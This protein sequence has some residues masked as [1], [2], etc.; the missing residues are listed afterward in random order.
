MRKRNLIKKL[1]SLGKRR[2]LLIVITAALLLEMLSAIQ[3]YFTHHL[4]EDELEKRAEMELTMKAIITNG[5]INSSERLLKSH[6]ME[7]KDNLSNPDSL[8]G[9]VEWTLK[10]APHL[11]GCGIA[12]RPGYYKGKGE[13]FEPYALRTDSGI[14]R[15]QVAGE[16]FDYTK[17]GFYRYIQEKKTNS[18]VGPYEDVYLKEKL[19]TYAVPIYDFT[20]DTVAVFG[21]DID[22][23]NLGDTLNK[24]HIYPSSFEFLL[25]E[26]GE[27]I[28][29]PP[30]TSL[31]KK[32]DDLIRVINDSTVKKTW[33]K[34]GRVR[35]IYYHD[36]DEGDDLSV[37]YASIRGAPHWQIAVVCYD[38]EVYA[39]LL[40]LRFRLLL[41]SMLA[42]GILLYMIHRFA[43]EEK[44]LNRKTLEQERI[45]GELRIANSIQQTLLPRD[46]ELLLKGITEVSVEGRL[47]PAKAVGGDLYNSFVRDGKLFFCIGDVSGKGVPSALIMAIVQALFRNIASTENSPDRIMKRLNESSCRNNK[48]NI[49]VTLFVGVLDLPTGR[50]RY[51]NAGHELPMLI[52]QHHTFLDAK[53][54]LP[55]GLFEDFNYEMQTIVMKPGSSMLLY[56]DG[57]TEARNARNEMFGRETLSQLIEDC[58]TTEP[59]VLVE[60]VISKWRHFI[61]TTQQ[62]DDLTLLALSYTPSLEQNIMEEG[63]ILHNDVNEVEAL[64]NFMKQVTEHLNLDKSLAKKLRLAVE[65][66]V[67]NVMEYAYPAGTTGEINIRATSNGNCLKFIIT[68]SGTS[69]NPTKV[70]TADTTLS[71]EERPIGGLGI[72]LVREL[73]DS[74]NYERIDGK[75]VLTLTKNICHTISNVE[76]P[77]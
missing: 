45:V 6:I 4:M 68:D 21:I 66:A 7:V 62:S 12:F 1:L 40:H 61:G 3:Y 20:R 70:Q 47:I 77:K 59:R 32:V 35:T 19:V 49:F 57:L 42:F 25:S 36:E 44:Q 43:K 23:R 30:D 31:K 37:F 5:I 58:G 60:A 67:V 29:G 48:A 52:D 64:R 15:L 27:L 71:A 28:A 11:K 54:N 41:F 55:I 13:L 8:P 72:M 50:L 18:W 76:I 38:D 75:N 26:K 73:M 51:C 2:G 46:D 9:I 69:F 53:P 22:P 33:I 24:R 65:E 39:P 14:L 16:R 56:T 34:E 17:D 63:L 10:Y 74:V